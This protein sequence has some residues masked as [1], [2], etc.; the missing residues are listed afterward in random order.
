M[1]KMDMNVKG[2]IL[3]SSAI[4]KSMNSVCPTV[5]MCLCLSVF[6]AVE[7]TRRLVIG[8]LQKVAFSEFLPEVGGQNP[9]S[10]C[11]ISGG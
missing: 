6:S 8:E 4:I 2:S 11:R 10:A 1:N 3:N 9:V 5:C 7:E